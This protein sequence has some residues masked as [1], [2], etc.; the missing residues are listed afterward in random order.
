MGSARKFEILWEPRS[1]SWAKDI[2]IL[3]MRV[4][5][6][7][8]SSRPFRYL[9]KSKSFKPFVGVLLSILVHVMAFVLI[10]QLDFSQSHQPSRI[11]E[12]SDQSP[13]Y[14]DL[15]ALKTLHILR[16]LPIIKP[17][18]A[19][20]RPGAAEKTVRVILQAATVQHPKFTMVI[21]PLKAD[22]NRQAITQPLSPPDLKILMEQNVPD[23]V[24]AEEPAVARPQVDMS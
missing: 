2:G 12:A 1:A 6:G 13:I 9:Q 5:E 15:E 18:G 14:L 7:S 4:P 19:G 3:F 22:N 21:N 24:L 8:V 17:A 23:I 10:T 20:G 16:S 11:V